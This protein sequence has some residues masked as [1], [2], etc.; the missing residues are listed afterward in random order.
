MTGM[1]VMKPVMDLAG[2]REVNH[3]NNTTINKYFNWPGAAYCGLTVKY[4]FKKSGCNLL[5]GCSNPAY[6][7]TIREYMLNQG[8]RIK[9]EDARAGDIICVG[10]NQHVCF[11][12]GEYSGATKITLEGN[13]TVYATAEQA[14]ASSAGTGAFE[15]IGYKKRYL[16][17]N[18]QVFRPPY[19]GG[20]GT[21]ATG[22]N[23]YIT[24]FQKWLNQN[25]AASLNVDGVFGR[26]TRQA[27]VKALQTYLNKTYSAG[28][29][30]DGGFGPKTKAFMAENKI[31]LKKGDKNDLV[32]ILQGMLYCRGYNPNGFDGK[33][34]GS[35]YAAVRAYQG[36]KNL[37]KDG[38]A[39][40]DTFASIMAA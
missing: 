2:E 13:A 23:T 37:A 3:N 26:L 40:A 22:Y 16:D 12:F 29:S 24:T 7:P 36:D 5:D 38:E 10:P 18:C 20:A 4:A 19:P 9:N 32:Y 31:E 1:D 27:A 30:V 21:S 6:L 28:L 14:R 17:A 8:W 33:F 25:Y 39:G 34:G 11:C 15:G 35:T